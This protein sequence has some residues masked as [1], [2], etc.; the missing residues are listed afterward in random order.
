MPL[1]DRPS[2]TVEERAAS[3]VNATLTGAQRFGPGPLNRWQG[4][5]A[6]C[7]AMLYAG[8]SLLVSD[9]AH[10]AGHSSAEA[11]RRH[12]EIEP[13]LGSRHTHGR[14]RKHKPP[15]HI[16]CAA[17]MLTGTETDSTAGVR[18]TRGSPSYEGKWFADGI[19]GRTPWGRSP[20]TPKVL[21]A[22][23]L[24]G[25]FCAAWELLLCMVWG[26]IPQKSR[27]LSGYRQPPQG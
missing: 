12:E 19:V 13:P 18:R 24:W 5:L 7:D 20:S 17:H 23:D 27:I 11:C 6:A 1:D 4:L 14:G 8:K 26:P 22:T 16:C 25:F 9:S 3:L 2:R 10:P 15:C 21:W